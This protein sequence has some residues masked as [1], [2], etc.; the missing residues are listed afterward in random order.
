MDTSIVLPKAERGGRETLTGCQSFSCPIRL[1]KSRAGQQEVPDMC[2]ATGHTCVYMFGCVQQIQ[3]CRLHGMSGD[4]QEEGLK[5]KGEKKC[6]RVCCKRKLVSRRKKEVEVGF[7][8][9]AAAT[10]GGRA[11]R[12]RAVSESSRDSLSGVG[13]EVSVVI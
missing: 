2:A 8:G 7:C 6:A 11:C 3:Q 5:R 4:E 9:E 13:N 1:R 12:R 10:A